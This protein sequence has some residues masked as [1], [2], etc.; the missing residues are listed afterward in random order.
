MATGCS[1]EDLASSFKCGTSTASK[2]VQDVCR[3]IWDKLQPIHLPTPNKTMWQDIANKFKNKA[4]FPNCL[5]SVDGKHIRIIHPPHS[6]SLF[7]N[8]KHFFSIVL[9]A[10]CD[11]DYLFVYA[12]VG[13]YG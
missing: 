12:D 6:W 13:A 10:V 1:L 2:I 8:Y 3:Q 11:A 9:M 7:W 4:N 5:G